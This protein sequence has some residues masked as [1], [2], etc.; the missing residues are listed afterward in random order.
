MEQYLRSFVNYLQE[1]WEDYL[2]LAEFAANNH[3]SE[4]TGLSPF[5]VNYGY[6]PRFTFPPSSSPPT[7]NEE[8]LADQNLARLSEIQDLCRSEM[9]RAQAAQQEQANKN[10]LP[11]PAFQVGDLVTLNARNIKTQRPARK[12]DWKRLGP[13]PVEAAVSSHAYRLTL[14]DTMK[15]HPVFHVSLLEPVSNDP[16][17]GQSN[18]P[19]PP[20]IVDGEEEFEVEE[21]LDS[22]L[23]GRNR[24]LQYLVRWSGYPD[25]TWEPAA[26]LSEVAAVDSFH[27]LFPSKPGPLSQELEP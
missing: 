14:P 11:A 25:P 26:N 10:R 13:F 2:P 12:L 6:H 24:R 4:S 15:V 23:F 27:A 17:P 7:S 1:D 19:P 5:F 22:R 3:V 21:V 16:L 8:L 20:V 18:P 9:L